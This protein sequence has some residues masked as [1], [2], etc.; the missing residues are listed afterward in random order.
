[1]IIFLSFGKKFG[2]RF[3]YMLEHFMLIP[4]NEKNVK[5][6]SKIFQNDRRLFQKKNKFPENGI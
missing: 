1:M 5:N 2:I 4:Q 6:L 3:T